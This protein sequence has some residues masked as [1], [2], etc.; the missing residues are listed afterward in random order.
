MVKKIS[1]R[2]DFDH[3]VILAHGTVN[4]WIYYHLNRSL[5][6]IHQKNCEVIM[7]NGE[8]K[9]KS[10]FLPKTFAPKGYMIPLENYIETEKV[11]V[12]K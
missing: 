12:K 5:Y 6:K 10:V 8:D 1:E 3:I 2:E 7:A 4:K 9:G 11:Y